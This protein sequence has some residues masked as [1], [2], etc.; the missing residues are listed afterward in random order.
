MRFRGESSSSL[1]LR[2]TPSRSD[3]LGFGW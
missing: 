1:E 3:A 2:N